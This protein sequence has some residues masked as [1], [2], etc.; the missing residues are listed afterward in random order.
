MA[1]TPIEGRA[2]AH[3]EIFREMHRQLRRMNPETPESAERL[4]PVLRMLMQLYAYQLSTIEKRVEE[5]WDRATKALIQS[6]YPEISRWPVPAFSVLQCQLLDPVVEID[7]NTKF[8]YQEKR[9]GGNTFYFS[10]FKPERLCKTTVRQMFAV[11]DQ[12]AVDLLASSTTAAKIPGRGQGFL[13]VGLAFDGRP[14]QLAGAQMFVHG[15]PQAT[16]QIIWGNWLPADATG[17]FREEF[18][19]CPGSRNAELKDELID[20]QWGGFRS[21]NDLFAILQEQ[22]LGLPESFVEKWD[23]SQISEDTREE[24]ARRGIAMPYDAE[25][26][27][28]LR[29]DLPAGG[30]RRALAETPRLLTDCCVVVNKDELSLFKH[31][32]TNRVIEMELPE[33]SEQV[34]GI[35]RV[36]DSRGTEYGTRSHYSSL[37]E[38]Y[39]YSTEERRDHI[40]VWIEIP[41]TADVIPESLTVFYGVT[42]GPKA[43]G[44]DPGKINEM[45]TP[46]PG[47]TSVANLLPSKGAVPARNEEQLMAEVAARLRGRDRA[48]SFADIQR[49]TASFDPRISRV[50]CRPGVERGERGMRRC[51]VV[52]AHVKADDFLSEVELELTRDRL[53]RFLTAR[54]AVN[55]RYKVEVITR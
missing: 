32:G 51:L 37:P 46:H 52:E 28:W 39:T 50:N 1:G 38:M 22:F 20:R 24:L 18:G 25:K 35:S 54:S 45:F 9:R 5:V 30:D 17:R 14:H 31:T 10:A 2:R 26:L 16:K 53:M 12:V 41:P 19:F 3:D 29:I 7:V 48:L 36:V 44:I 55:T 47:I 42:L 21:T 49:W 23:P 27:F 11:V 13:L 33:P 4:D 34:L 6:M 15:Q 8:S 43:N 40:V